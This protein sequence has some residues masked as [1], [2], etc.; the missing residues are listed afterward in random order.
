MECTDK[1]HAEL[2][3]TDELWTALPRLGDQIYTDSDGRTIRLELRNCLC[4]S[5]LSRR[6]VERAVRRTEQGFAGCL[7]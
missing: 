2:R 1:T 4:G 7:P 6:T 5:T 3:S